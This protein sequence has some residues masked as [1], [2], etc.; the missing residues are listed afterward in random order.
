M[1]V[2]AARAGATSDGIARRHG[3]WARKGIDGDGDERIA[4]SREERGHES[5]TYLVAG[6]AEDDEVLV[7]VFLVQGLKTL[8][9]RREAA[10]WKKRK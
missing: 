4:I 1:G 7:L 10:A 3:M 6:E 9:L 2:V 8:V 5:R